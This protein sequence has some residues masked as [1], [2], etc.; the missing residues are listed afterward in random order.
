MS[1]EIK[2][3]KQGVRDLSYLKA[4]PRIVRDVNELPA[5]LLSDCKHPWHKRLT[6]PDNEKKCVGCGKMW[7]G[8]GNEFED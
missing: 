4:P 2:M 3:T 5:Y 1:V 6:L 7:D 8:E